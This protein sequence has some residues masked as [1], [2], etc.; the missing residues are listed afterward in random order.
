MSNETM[1][2]R[3]RTRGAMA[4]AAG[5]M[6]M[7]MWS[8]I[9]LWLA[10]V[11]FWSPLNLIAHTVWRGAPLGATFSGGALVLGLVIH[12]MMSMILG[13]VLAVGV[14]TV[15]RLGRNPVTVATT[16]MVFGLVVWVVM[17]Y[18]IWKAVDP[19]AAPLFTAWVFALGHLMFG[20]ATGLLIGTTSVRQG[21][22]VPY[23]HGI[24]A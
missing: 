11:G 23:A 5:G 22:R 9:V 24:P 10:G 18:V 6:V 8:M 19:A 14:R 3:T 17:Q 21:A 15:S 7:A 12:M 20:A 1:S 4:G 13:M 2:A 16:G